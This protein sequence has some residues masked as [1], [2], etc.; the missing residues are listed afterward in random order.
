MLLDWAPGLGH[1]RSRPRR[2]RGGDRG[3]SGGRGLDGRPSRRPGERR[4]RSETGATERMGRMGRTAGTAAFYDVGAERR[5]FEEVWTEENYAVLTECLARLPVHWRFYAKHRIFATVERADRGRTA[6]RRIGGAPR[7]RR[8]LHRVS[9]ALGGHRRHL[10]LVLFKPSDDLWR[11]SCPSQIGQGRWLPE[12]SQID[13]WTAADRERGCGARCLR[14]VRRRRRDRGE[15]VPKSQVLRRPPVRGWTWP[16]LR[17]LRPLRPTS[18][19]GGELLHGSE[20]S[21]V[22]AP[23]SPRV[24]RKRSSKNGLLDQ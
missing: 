14:P 19:I 11:Q 22:S 24:G 4:E 13:R 2:L 17:G 20:D 1:D 18:L 15:S 10:T 6:R 7:L 21:A 12:G 8:P 3:R 5:A 9:A 16:R 23:A